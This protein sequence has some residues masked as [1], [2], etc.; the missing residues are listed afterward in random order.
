MSDNKFYFCIKHHAVEGEAGCKAID[1][2]GPYDTEAEAERA[3]EKAAER[4]EAWENDPDWNDDPP[5]DR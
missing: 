2:L 5:S 3:L 4:N 1:R